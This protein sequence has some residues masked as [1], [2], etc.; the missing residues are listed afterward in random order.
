M[1][2]QVQQRACLSAEMWAGLNFSADRVG[3]FMAVAPQAI[4]RWVFDLLLY[5][6]TVVPLQDFLVPAVLASHLGER[7]CIRLLEEGAL[8]FA[9]LHGCIGF[10]T[11]STG[12]LENGAVISF[13]HPSHA[14]GQ[15]HDKPPSPP[16]TDSLVAEAS[17]GLREML[18]RAPDS[19]LVKL[20]TQSTTEHATSQLVDDCGPRIIAELK[21][22]EG[23]RTWAGVPTGAKTAEREKPARVLTTYGGVLTGTGPE[24]HVK[25]LSLV[26][27]YAELWLAGATQASDLSTSAPVQRL[28]STTS[29]RHLLADDRH[30]AFGQLQELTHVPDVG[31][32]V[33]RS[34]DLMTEFLRLRSSV[35]G[36][37]F[38]K[39][40]HQNATMAGPDFARATADLLRTGDFI[41]SWPA[42]ILRYAITSIPMA[43]T[44]GALASVF[45][46]FIADS[47]FR[48]RGAKLFVERLE[49]FDRETPNAN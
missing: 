38:R 27:A 14:R 8:S 36:K 23:L 42:R 15:P 3:N 10:T 28:L 34:P 16:S 21:T 17:S 48:D 40:F 7:N 4:P 22:N 29:F 1:A 9:R 35:E 12:V 6:R 25:V 32:V 39:W 41:S 46:S 19:R 5:D 49:R 24:P 18:G 31:Q 30:S 20:W 33:F 37:A 43:A 47:L 2:T 44:L 26:G 13:V 45:D 11:P